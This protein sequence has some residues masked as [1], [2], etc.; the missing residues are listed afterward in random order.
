M[1]ETWRAMK[2]EGGMPS[3]GA[4]LE[5]DRAIL[6]SAL[7][8]RAQAGDREAFEILIRARLGR[9]LR[10]ALSIVGNEADARDAVQEGCLRT[11]REL[12][13]LREVD[14]FEA[15]LWRITINAC[16]SSLRNR[17]RTNV[18]EI[19]VDALPAD[20]PPID[21]GN[22]F[23]DDVTVRDAIRRAFGRLDADKR[24][25]LVLHHVEDRSVTEIAHLLGIPEGTAKSRLHSARRS[26]ER[27]LEME[28]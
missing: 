12:P 25:I 27:A 1:D 23:A 5:T 14:R 13:R 19:A 15:W 3:E 16:R 8:E 26:L 20:R 24:T 6:G 7:V 17:R 28:R 9:L 10:L 22:G 18:H 4:R 21:S 2:V 11:W